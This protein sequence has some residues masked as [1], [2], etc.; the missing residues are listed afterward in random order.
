M[1]SRLVV[2]EFTCELAALFLFPSFSCCPRLWRETCK[3]TKKKRR[4]PPPTTKF[5]L[6]RRL[7]TIAT[8]VALSLPLSPSLDCVP[9]CPVEM[10]EQIYQQQQLTVFLQDN[11]RRPLPLPAYRRQ[12]HTRRR[13]F[14]AAS[15]REF[16]VPCSEIGVENS[17][18]EP[19]VCVAW[20]E[21]SHQVFSAPCVRLSRGLKS[22]QQLTISCLV[23]C[24]PT[25]S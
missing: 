9:I 19:L 3:L 7:M 5:Q 23:G 13:N 4:A 11:W 2:L 25:S 20:K 24:C 14:R 15:R 18:F 6:D 16:R 17:Q 10:R 1:F 12:C 8:A 22:R 21:A